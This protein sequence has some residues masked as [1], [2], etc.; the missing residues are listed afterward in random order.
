MTAAAPDD[1]N[2]PPARSFLASAALCAFYGLGIIIALVFY[3]F[4]QERI[5]AH[6]YGKSDMFKYSVFLVFWNR[7]VAI[8]FAVCMMLIKREQKRWA[9][10]LWKYF[11]ISISNVAATSCQYEA[12]KYVTFPVQMLGKS[13][14]MMP[15][16]CWG[17]LISGKRYGLTDWLVAFGVT[18]GVT[19]FLLT[20]HISESKHHNA[21][22]WGLLLLVLFLL[23]DGFTSTFQEKLFKEHKTS[24][25]NQM[26]YVNTGSAVIAFVTLCASRTLTKSF[27]FAGEHPVLFADAF[28][29][30][31]AAVAGQFFIYGQV[32]EFGALVFAATMNVRQVI[33]ILVSYVIYKHSITGLQILAF[34]IVFAA[35]FYSSAQGFFQSKK[36]NRSEETPLKDKGDSNFPFTQ[37][38]RSFFQ[39]KKKPDEETPVQE[40]KDAP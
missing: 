12:L 5:M 34:I 4:L 7:I 36:G 25:Y 13:F 33:S 1:R 35:L 22:F 14:K 31:I 37:Y 3:G 21:S 10:P 27:H 19:M 39:P 24:R 18:G 29:L 16:M 9:A 40:K 26:C 2:A 28:Y 20:G 8:I 17:M 11:A 15:V 30:S 38:V 32:E 6:P 23:F